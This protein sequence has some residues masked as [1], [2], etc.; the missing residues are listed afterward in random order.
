M[1]NSGIEMNIIRPWEPNMGFH[2]VVLL[3]STELPMDGR[4]V[5][6]R[7][8]HRRLLELFNASVVLWIGA[9]SCMCKHRNPTCSEDPMAATGFEPSCGRK[10]ACRP[11]GTAL[12]H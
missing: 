1:R 11:H 7:H 10:E 9:L 12:Q 2:I 3:N 6:C 5:E 8:R 4:S